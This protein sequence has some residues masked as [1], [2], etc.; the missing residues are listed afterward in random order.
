MDSGDTGLMRENGDCV[1][2]HALPT[3]NLVQVRLV[4]VITNSMRVSGLQ[5]HSS[6]AVVDRGKPIKAGNIVHVR[7]NGDEIM[8][9]L[10]RRAGQ[11]FLQ[12]D[13]PTIHDVVIS[14]DDIVERLSVIIAAIIFIQ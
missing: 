3:G 13:G 11:W 1:D 8:R 2:L 12:A 14:E 6:I 10:V 7:Y 5:H 9:R 4:K